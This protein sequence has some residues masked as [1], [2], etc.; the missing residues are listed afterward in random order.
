VDHGITANDKIA[1]AKELGIDVV[2]CDHHQLGE[3][4]PDC[5]AIVHTDKVCAAAISWLLSQEVQSAKCK[6]QNGREN[7]LDLVAIATIAD[8]EPLIGVNRSFAQYGLKAL[9]Q[10]T[11]SGLQAI[12]DEA[13]IKKEDI[14]TYHVGYMIAPRLN[15]M[16]RMEHALD[17]LRLV[18]TKDINQAKDLAAK[19]GITN[20]ERQ[21]LTEETA[22]HAVESAKLK[23][24]SEKLIFIGHETY[25][26]GIIG[27][28]AGKL[29]EHY[30]R[31]AVVLSIGEIYSKAS[32]RSISGFNII[33]AIRLQSDLL[34]DAGG[35]PM[36]AGF[37]VETTKI[38]LLKQ[39]LI[40]EAGK[41]ITDSMLEKTLNIDMELPLSGVT[42]GLWEKIQDL[43]PFGIGNP[44]PVFSCK[45]LV[46]DFRL[47]G[48]EGKHIKFRL[49]DG[50]SVISA[51][52][53][54]MGKNA[55]RLKVDQEVEVAYNLS[56]NEWNN[57]RR[58]ELKI[59]DLKWTT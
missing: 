48:A 21:V 37:T 18:C 50:K 8:L 47:V 16:G 3:K 44:E 27:L 38:E 49:S 32:A 11:R 59:R 35:H 54:G 22:R 12:F 1:Y 41:H 26:Q 43:S 25:E 4:V 28:V 56:L 52:G 45:V 51:I 14:N 24:Q 2:V 58:V 39:R 6:V 31:P 34:V 33:E 55:E 19:L 57:E 53:F 30:Y 46:K 42:L 17:S 5:A 40:D 23:V 9:R 10:T 13:G 20:K 7:Y 36:A 29:V 15:A